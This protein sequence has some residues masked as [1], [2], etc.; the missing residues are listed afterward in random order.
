MHG[1]IEPIKENINASKP[2]SAF[3]PQKAGFIA[4]GMAILASSAGIRATKMQAS[5]IVF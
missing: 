1:R 2:E 3:S 4:K 5:Q